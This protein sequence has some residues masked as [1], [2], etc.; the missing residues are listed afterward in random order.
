MRTN[1]L[2]GLHSISLVAV[3]ISFCFAFSV[4]AVEGETDGFACPD[5]AVISQPGTVPGTG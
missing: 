2:C 3:L 1:V 5:N 4:Y